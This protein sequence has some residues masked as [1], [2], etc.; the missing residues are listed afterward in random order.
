MIDYYQVLGV[1]PTAEA[2]VIKAAYRALISIYHPDR[3]SAASAQEKTK[4]INEAY[5]VLS[6][7]IRKSE[8]DRGRISEEHNA[9]S[10]AFDQT[11][12]FETDPLEKSWS[13]AVC[14]F[15]E[16]QDE[17]EYLGRISWR[18]A[19]AFKLQLSESQEYQNYR[20]IAQ[21]IRSEYLARYFGKNVEISRFAEKLILAGEIHIALYLNE[22]VNVMGR[23]V[24]Y[25]QVQRM[26]EKK[27]PGI[28]KRIRG[29]SLYR[30]LVKRSE[31]Y[32]SDLDA[33]EFVNL[34]GG[35]ARRSIWTGKITLQFNGEKFTFATDEDFYSF[36]AEKFSMLYG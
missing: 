13:I 22:I 29:K 8:Y 11:R 33:S 31:H 15:P 10:A 21:K 7:P 6:D 9:N 2:V 4:E 18:L 19:F 36:L 28:E 26:V 1:I 35:M 27:F 32:F 25:L 34:I 3:N 24:D 30:R 12:P 5:S 23:S 14:F 17:Y 20:E 16:L